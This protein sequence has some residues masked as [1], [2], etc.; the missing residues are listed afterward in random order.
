MIGDIVEVIVD[1]PLGSCH[2]NHKDMYYPINYG[3]VKGIIAPDGEEQDAYILGV[4]EPVDKFT[5]KVVAIIHRFDDVEEKWV[6]APEDKT[7]S[8][9]E[10]KAQVAF[11]EQYFNIE[12]RM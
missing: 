7:F 3:Y 10:I 11:Q 8:L 2:P 1:R 5:G 9:E 6:V 4:D 12:I